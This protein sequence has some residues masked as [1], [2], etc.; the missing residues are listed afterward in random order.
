MEDDRAAAATAAEAAVKLQA[1][2]RGYNVRKRQP[3]TQL[4]KIDNVKRTLRELQ[5]RA[6]DPAYIE[7]ICVEVMECRK[8]T[9]GIM[10]LVL[11]LDALQDIHPVVRDIRKSVNREVV[12]F[13]ELID[14]VVVGAPTSP[15]L[16]TKNNPNMG[17]SN[18]MSHIDTVCNHSLKRMHSLDNCT[19]PE[20]ASKRQLDSRLKFGQ[21]KED[22][23]MMSPLRGSSPEDGEIGSVVGNSGQEGM[24]CHSELEA[25]RAVTAAV[26]IQ[27]MYRGYRVRRSRPLKHLRNIADVR[28][29]LRVLTAQVSKRNFDSK[30]RSDKRE[31]LRVTECITALLLQLDSVQGV[32][33]VIRDIRKSITGEVFKLQELVDK[34]ISSPDIVERGLAPPCNNTEPEVHDLSEDQAR[35]NECCSLDERQ[36]EGDNSAEEDAPLYALSLDNT[37]HERLDDEVGPMT[38]DCDQQRDRMEPDESSSYPSA[39]DNCEVKELDRVEV[40][41][42]DRFMQSNATTSSSSEFAEWNGSS[43]GESGPCAAVFSEKDYSSHVSDD[44]S[45]TVSALKSEG[46]LL[47][48]SEDFP[49]SNSLNNEAIVAREQLGD[50]A[51][52]GSA[53]ELGEENIKLRGLLHQ[54]LMSAEMQNSMVSKM[55]DT[56][57]KLMSKMMETNE[58]LEAENARHRKREKRSR[59]MRRRR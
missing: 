6:A 14:A 21:N 45:G 34:L 4:R 13:M 39:E 49:A 28:A 56:N 11:Q 8:L 3:L 38:P 16:E 44:P 40:R 7:R 31:R 20:Q 19:Y 12:Q 54:V 2:V 17:R 1:A 41:V 53:G 24:E 55:M 5:E 42:P 58:K 18:S 26:I 27:S 32:D 22:V 33:Q 10:A 50:V 29:K 23:D 15:W 57:E 30:L 51:R 43:D 36:T 35:D 25:L 52:T 9:E 37:G 47:Q 46:L 48:K 59:S